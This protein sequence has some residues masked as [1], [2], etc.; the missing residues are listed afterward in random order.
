[1]QWRSIVTGQ[2]GRMGAAFYVVDT[3]GEELWRIDD[4]TAPG[5]AVLE[6]SFPSGLSNATGI[7]SHGGAL[8]VVDDCTGDELWRIDDPTAPGFGSPGG[9]IPIRARGPERYHIARRGALRGGQ[10]RRPTELWRIED[11]TAPGFGG[12]GRLIP[13]R[14]LATSE[15]YHIARRG[16]LRGGQS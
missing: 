7:T 13:I 6:D 15:R 14:D 5:S 10:L 2:I 11:P 8:Y 16:A 12:P 9:H 4:P 1:M 3:T